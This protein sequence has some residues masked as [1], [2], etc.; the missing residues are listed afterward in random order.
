[1]RIALGQTVLSSDGQKIGVIERVLFGSPGNVVEHVVVH[2]GITLQ[3][4]MVVSRIKI[5]RVDAS[6]VHLSLD[7]EATKQLPRFDYSFAAIEADAVEI[8]PPS[9][10]PGM[11]LFPDLTPVIQEAPADATAS[12]PAGEG[13]DLNADRPG[14][15]PGVV[16]GKGADVVAA[17]GQHVGNVAEVEYGD[18]GSLETVTVQTGLLR[19]HRFTV[20]ADQIA[21]IGDEEMVLNVP[22]GQ[23]PEPE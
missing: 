20:Q 3:D 17:D 13:P 22:A 2:H 10:I 5:E 16:I 19:H 11:I 9:P 18:D 6:G 23:L 21:A 1:M 4:D 7:A 14:R 12:V 15:T 8:T